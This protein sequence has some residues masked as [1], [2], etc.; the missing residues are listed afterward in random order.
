MPLA[1]ISRQDLFKAC[2]SLFGTEI[3]ISIEFLRYLKPAGVKAAYRKKAME[4]HPDRAA[5]LAGRA[6]FM[7]D[8]FK[9]VSRAYQLLCAFLAAPWKYSLNEE[10]TLYERKRAAPRPTA[11][12]RAP[13]RPA[14]GRPEPLYSGRMPLR[15][16]LFGQYLYY[17]GDI[18]LSTLIKA[19]VWQ[20]LQRPSVGAIAVSW[21][22][23]EGSDILDILRIRKSGEKF[24][25]CAVRLGRL[26]R[27]QLHKLL[28]K[29]K[30]I[31]PLIGK[32]FTEND[33]FSSTEVFRKII[34]MKMHN[35]KFWSY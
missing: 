30:L 28:E 2:E 18:S 14:S 6:D 31:Q 5:A 10:G 32:Y 24:G 25:E 19:I 29:Q 16:L 26:S 21:G 1:D 33:I 34:D 12:R 23:L 8:R 7:E 15:R 4:T 11:R 9:E 35:R 3:D 17:S 13:S 27:H 22:W 20:K